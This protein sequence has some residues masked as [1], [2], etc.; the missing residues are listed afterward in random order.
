[1]KYVYMMYSCIIMPPQRI[2]ILMELRFFIMQES[3]YRS[4]YYYYYYSLCH[5]MSHQVLKNKTRL[6][7]C[8]PRK[9]THTT[10]EAIV[11]KTMLYS[12]N[13]LIINTYIRESWN[14]N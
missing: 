5:H 10:T 11:S 4:Y 2:F 7:I 9:S 8:V 3:K 6:A 13:I 12:R 14:G 1:M